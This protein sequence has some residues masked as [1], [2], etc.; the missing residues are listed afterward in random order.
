MHDFPTSEEQSFKIRA[1]VVCVFL[2]FMKLFLC[3]AAR[4]EPVGLLL[5]HLP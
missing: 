1:Q 4:G 2:F 5:L 3:R